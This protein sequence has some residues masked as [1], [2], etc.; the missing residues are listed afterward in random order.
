M[1][2]IVYVEPSH[3]NC[4]KTL[5]RCF[6]KTHQMYCTRRVAE[7]TLIS[8]HNQKIGKPNNLNLGAIKPKGLNM[9]A[10]I[11]YGHICLR[12]E[13]LISCKVRDVVNTRRLLSHQF[14]IYVYWMLKHVQ[15]TF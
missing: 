15:G 4:R 11:G 10:Q 12:E 14:C 6:M 9:I 13:N 2:K 5:L 3:T 7:V 8:T 1:A